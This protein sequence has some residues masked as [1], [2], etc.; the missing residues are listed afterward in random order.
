MGYPFH[1]GETDLLSGATRVVPLDEED[2]RPWLQAVPAGVKQLLTFIHEVTHHWCFNSGVV[3][4]LQHVSTRL[5]INTAVFLALGKDPAPQLEKGSVQWFVCTFGQL[6][7]AIHGDRRVTSAQQM[8]A[9]RSELLAAIKD[10]LVRLQVTQALLRPLAEGLA[11][12][13]EYDATSRALSRSATPLPWAIAWNFADTDMMRE[14]YASMPEPEKSLFLAGELVADARLSRAA[15]KAKASVLAQPLSSTAG[16]YLPGYLAVRN[17]WR[18]LYTQSF[19]LYGESDLVL[20]YLRQFFYDDAALSAAILTSPGRDLEESTNGIIRAFNRRLLEFE[21]V[22]PEKVAELDK[23]VSNADI[24]KLPPHCPGM[25]RT[26]DEERSARASIDAAITEYQRTGLSAQIYPDIVGESILRL[27][28]VLNRRDNV[29]TCSVPV[30]ISRNAGEDGL[31]IS[32]RGT[33]VLH[34]PETD[35]LRGVDHAYRGKPFPALDGPGQLDIV[36]SDFSQDSGYGGL[37]RSA[38]ISRE[39]QVIS[40]TFFGLPGERDSVRESIRESFGSRAEQISIARRSEILTSWLIDD[41]PE[42][43]IMSDYL[44]ENLV[45]IVDSAY[46]DTALWPARDESAVDECALLMRERGLYKLFGSTDLLKRVALF[47]LAAGVNPKG[48]DIVQVFARH[49]YDFDAFEDT[50]GQV[51]ASWEHHGFP[52]SVQSA[53]SG[54][55]IILV[56]QI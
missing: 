11:L 32:W 9:W 29:I 48:R 4:A 31:E 41:N 14:P 34:V 43:R 51:R 30:T 16:G 2:P 25:L 13:A 17:M 39:G 10:D 22:T 54:E 18:H 56:P 53:R 47:G 28:G 20:M 3:N 50:I 21:R 7:R 45:A 1:L 35:R 15:V 40:S 52:R 37:A 38:V 27:D 19:D 6:E 24:A 12:F 36:M 44:T 26:A 46:R 23:H 33:H 5:E 8:R 55:D 49:G 42:M